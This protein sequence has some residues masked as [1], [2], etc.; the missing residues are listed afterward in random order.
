MEIE[1]ILKCLKVGILALAGYK[2]Y[3]LRLMRSHTMEDLKIVGPA[4]AEYRAHG[5]SF[6]SGKGIF[7]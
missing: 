3:V 7:R 5:N 4:M 2:N 6:I 1:A